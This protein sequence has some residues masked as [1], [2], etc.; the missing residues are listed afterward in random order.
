MTGVDM[1]SFNGNLARAAACL[2]SGGL[3]ALSGSLHPVWAAAWAA[4]VPVLVAAFLS[5]RRTGFVLAYLAGL[6]GNLP[7]SLYMI[8]VA[9]P[10]A[11][12]VVTVVLALA[13]A[14][15]VALA[16]GARR[17]LQPA[18][19]VFAFPA[20]G[21][22]LAT[23]IAH[24]SQDGTAASLAYSQMDFT[25][26]LQVAALGGAPAVVFLVC[27]FASGLAFALAEL[28][29][30][31]RALAAAAP[32]ALV[33]L[34]GLGFGAWRLSAAP[35]EPTVTVAMAALDQTSEL[36]SDWRATLA[37]YR[38][39]LEEAQ[40]K[41]ARLLV[42]P[43]EISLIAARDLPA[44][45]DELG[46]YARSS[47]VTLAASFRV[48]EPPKARN[49]L[50]LF[51]PDGRVAAYDK[52]HLI[53]GLESARVAAGQ[54]PVLAAQAGGLSLGGAICKDFDFVDTSRG[55][56]RAGAQLAVGPAWDFGEDAWL[57]G[58]MAMLRA[59]EGGFTLVRSARRGEMSVSDRYGR[60]LAEARSGPDAPL[61]VVQAPVPHA[62]APLYARTGDAF[63]WACAAFVVLIWRTGLF[64]R[65]RG[66][67]RSEASPVQSSI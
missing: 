53:T 52:R 54:G 6:I 7:L 36:P 24:L 39:R 25:P 18:L 57:H 21:A 49:R 43:E 67:L 13:Y 29:A 55:L 19:A 30:P 44:M 10:V 12:V 59:V 5:S 26:V 50:Y 61:L 42:L 22:G 56:A 20:W 40:A 58:R 2:A 8:A 27:L 32:A 9:P 63:G 34:A 14:G 3:L 41:R 38:S 33:V 45:Q 62:G 37:A 1:S 4:S 31:R 35:V 60:V 16:A 28:K 47:G 51:T 64:G 65:K 23:A 17:R 11:V 15:G 48:M 46:A 66:P